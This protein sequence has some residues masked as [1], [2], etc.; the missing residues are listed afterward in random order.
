MLALAYWVAYGFLRR[1][2]GQNRLQNRA[3]NSATPG[4][5]EY[6]FDSKRYNLQG[7][8]ALVNGYIEGTCLSMRS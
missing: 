3:V 2:R 1:K 6:Q 8:M 7:Q 5:K 4:R